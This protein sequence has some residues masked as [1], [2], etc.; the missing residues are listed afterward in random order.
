MSP[1][2]KEVCHYGDSAISRVA[3]IRSIILL[4]CALKISSREL[5]TATTYYG[6]KKDDRA[7]P[8]IKLA[9]RQKL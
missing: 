6:R 8:Q 3:S 5:R 1:L 2:S 7:K 4:A 9:D